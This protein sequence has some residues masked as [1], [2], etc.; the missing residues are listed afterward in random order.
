[1]KLKKLMSIFNVFI[2][3][4][5]SELP[6]Y[7]QGIIN[8]EKIVNILEDDYLLVDPIKKQFNEKFRNIEQNFGIGAIEDNKFKIKSTF[9]TETRIKEFF[10]LKSIRLVN[11]KKELYFRFKDE[12]PTINGDSCDLFE[13]FDYTIRLHPFRSTINTKFSNEVVSRTWEMDAQELFDYL[14]ENMEQ[15]FKFTRKFKELLETFYKH[16]EDEQLQLIFSQHNQTLGRI[17]GILEEIKETSF[18]LNSENI[19]G[20]LDIMNKLHSV[21]SDRF[22][23]IELKEK[24]IQENEKSL[25]LELQESKQMKFEKILDLERELQT[26]YLT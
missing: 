2:T 8:L 24:E 21:C 15:S 16:S 25:L 14:D 23:A 9:T 7:A 17:F 4:K 18:T 20:V 5:K 3:N 13:M 26:K 11:T 6:E 1:M 22:K 10:P 12:L 19:N